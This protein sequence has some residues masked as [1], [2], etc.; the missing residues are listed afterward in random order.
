MAEEH[1]QDRHPIGTPLTVAAGMA[2]VCSLLFHGAELVNISINADEENW[3]G[4]PDPTGFLL[5]GRWGLYLATRILLPDSVFPITSLAIFLIAYSIC[6][7][8]L[9]KRLDIQSPISVV[10][11]SPFF[12]G[13]PSLIYALVYSPLS[14]ALG[15]GILAATAVLYLSQRRTLT[16]L[17]FCSL[18]IAFGVSV[19]QS[20]IWYAIVVFVADVAACGMRVEQKN[21]AHCY[22]MALWYAAITVLGLILYVLSSFL[23]LSWYGGHIQVLQGYVNFELLLKNPLKALELTL[24]EI[25]SIYGGWAPF[26]ITQNLFYRLLTGCLGLILILRIA[27]APISGAR[28]AGVLLLAIIIVLIP[29]LQH[30]TAAGFLPYR[31]LVGVPA[32]LAILAFF[33]TEGATDRVRHWVLLPLSFL[34]II[35]F[36]AISN[37]QYYAGILVN[38]RDRLMAWEMVSRI[39]QV[40]PQQP[41]YKIAIIGMGPLFDDFAVPVVPSSTLGTSLFQINGGNSDRVAG[42]LILVSGTNFT[43]ATAPEWEAAYDVA[44]K[45]PPWPSA[46]SISQLAGVTV[47]KLGEPTSEQIQLVCLGRQSEFCSRHR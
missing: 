11:A 2:L 4:R 7:I 30:P 18:L 20:I 21:P 46:G 38:Q 27:T 26:F 10:V 33:A 40:V 45:M 13:F 22:Q 47:I 9:V 8:L 5:L 37:R 15:L 25:L 17:I 32:A 24:V 44:L 34:L 43:A 41:V 1:A 23:L 28:R 35:E 29:F 36:S 12:F 3:M 42:L 31:S 6:F 16:K 39:K 19:Y 14:F